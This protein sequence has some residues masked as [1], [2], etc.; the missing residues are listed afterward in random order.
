MNEIPALQ[1]HETMDFE[2]SG[3]L[4]GAAFKAGR[5]EG[6]LIVDSF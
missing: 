1:N 6:L 3:F 4:S 5:I 2:I